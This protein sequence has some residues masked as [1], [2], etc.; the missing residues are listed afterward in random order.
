MKTANLI[1]NW[2]LSDATC[3]CTERPPSPFDQIWRQRDNNLNFQS[4]QWTG[5]NLE[6]QSRVFKNP[7][8]PSLSWI[9][10]NLEIY[11]AP[12]QDFKIQ[13]LN[14]WMSWENLCPNLGF[15]VESKMG[16]SHKRRWS[17]FIWDIPFPKMLR[18]YQLIGKNIFHWGKWNNPLSW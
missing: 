12:D 17:H 6:I 18:I 7:N 14:L 5:K 15:T 13:M 1:I 16:N 3:H 10:K 4:F 11:T 8:F 2:L 9:I